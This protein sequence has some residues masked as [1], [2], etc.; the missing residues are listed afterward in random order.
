MNSYKTK[1][2]YL[3]DYIISSGVYLRWTVTGETMELE[4]L[5]RYLMDQL[6]QVRY[7]MDQSDLVRYQLDLVRYQ[8]DPVRYR[9]N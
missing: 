1:I 3:V 9:M 2:V 7:I 5:V 6:D 4:D 8:S